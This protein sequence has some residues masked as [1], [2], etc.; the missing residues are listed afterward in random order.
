MVN[1]KD[2]IYRVTACLEN[3]SENFYSSLGNVRDF[4][5]NRRKVK[6]ISE[7]YLVKE[8]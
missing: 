8:N 7:K 6:E 4:S 1:K 2:V 3:R 5:Q